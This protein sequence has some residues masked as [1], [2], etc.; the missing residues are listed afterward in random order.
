MPQK[1]TRQQV[2]FNALDRR[3][4]SLYEYLMDNFSWLGENEKEIQSRFDDLSKVMNK[5]EQ[6]LNKSS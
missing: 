2:C 1:R 4:S 3:L 5:L 6:S